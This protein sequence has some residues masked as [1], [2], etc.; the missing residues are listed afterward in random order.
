MTGMRCGETRSEFGLGGCKWREISLF[1][2]QRSGIIR[3][4]NLRE[5]NNIRASKKSTMNRSGLLF[6]FFVLSFRLPLSLF[7]FLCN[8]KLLH[9]LLVYILITCTIYIHFIGYIQKY[10]LYGRFK[11]FL[12]AIL[13]TRDFWF[14]RQPP[15][16]MDST[17][18]KYFQYTA[19]DGHFSCNKT[20]SRLV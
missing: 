4:I 17:V 6:S 7:L 13:T 9:I 10:V 20:T 11:G 14:R 15:R 19:S 8:L 5:F 1:L 18:L 2:V 12:G 16:K 3:S